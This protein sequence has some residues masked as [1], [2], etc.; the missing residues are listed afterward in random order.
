MSSENKEVQAVLAMLE[1]ILEENI[2]EK[3][4]GET[5]ITVHQNQGGIRS[6]T[7]CIKQQMK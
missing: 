7:K 3:F 2:E 6:W 1:K 5:S 4:T